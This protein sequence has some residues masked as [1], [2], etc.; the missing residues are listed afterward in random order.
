M[1]DRDVDLEGW[2]LWKI[3]PSTLSEADVVALEVEF[4]VRFP[5][6]FRAYL[7]AAFHL[8]NQVHSR[9]H[10]LSNGSGQLILNT[11]VPSDQPLEPLRSLINAWRPV[12][13]AGYV[14]FAQWGDGWG[15]MC[16]DMSNRHPDGD[17]P[18]VWIDHEPL[19]SLDP[20]SLSDRKML[21][22]LAQPLYD[23]YRECFDD[24]FSVS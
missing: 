13:S 16:F 4:S 22:P 12:D 14:A 10:I 9:K 8:F 3:I 7:L 24:M 20:S 6:L 21:L 2:A 17:C 11:P 23:S 15:A 5:P 18:V 19:V 1:L